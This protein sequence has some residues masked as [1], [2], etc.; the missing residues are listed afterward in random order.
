MTGKE[1]CGLELAA[2]DTVAGDAMKVEIDVDGVLLAE[3]DGAVDL[4]KRLIVNVRPVGGL[5]PNPVGKRQARKV[6][7]PLLHQG[8]IRLLEGWLG[9]VTRLPLPLYIEAAVARDVLRGNNRKVGRLL[10]RNARLRPEEA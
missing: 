7:T 6:E 1:V 9:V 10:G 2:V 8:E 5:A 3:I 4:G